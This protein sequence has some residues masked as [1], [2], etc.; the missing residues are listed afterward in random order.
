M[1]IT[2]WLVVRVRSCGGGTI[3]YAHLF[4]VTTKW[5]LG[6]TCQCPERRSPGLRMERGP[7]HTLGTT[8]RIRYVRW[9]SYWYVDVGFDA[10][11][12]LL[13]HRWDRVGQGGVTI[14]HTGLCAILHALA[15]TQ[16]KSPALPGVT[17]ATPS[18]H[19]P[20]NFRCIQWFPHRYILNDSRTF[21]RDCPPG[22]CQCLVLH[23]IWIVVCQLVDTNSLRIQPSVG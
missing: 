22:Q 4:R 12:L 6:P 3:F 23:G 16:I 10:C 14:T 8:R 5:L 1:A 13:L 2:H 9:L 20:P 19:K 15:G 17:Q 21:S 11:L 7:H 18:I